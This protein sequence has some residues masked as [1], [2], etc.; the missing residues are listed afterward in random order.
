MD[1]PQFLTLSGLKGSLSV[2]MEDTS[3][4]ARYQEYVDA[5]NEWVHLEL[6]AVADQSA[7]ERDGY[8]R[9][10]AYWA[11]L[12]HARGM[13][14][15]QEGWIEKARGMFERAQRDIDALVRRAQAQRGGRQRLVGASRGLAE[16]QV[17]S[18]GMVSGYVTRAL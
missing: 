7:I 8:F 6:S 1:A 10:K 2:P 17:L 16:P 5:G 14:F 11:A 15:E 12:S 13:A 9:K 18:G 3:D 4:D